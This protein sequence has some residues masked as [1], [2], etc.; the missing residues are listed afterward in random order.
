MEVFWLWETV[1]GLKTGWH[2]SVGKRKQLLYIF[3]AD[4]YS[5][6]ITFVLASGL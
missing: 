5:Q 2:L 1:K 6:E 3:F 4:I